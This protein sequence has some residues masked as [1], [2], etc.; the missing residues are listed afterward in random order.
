MTGGAIPEASWRPEREIEI[1]AGTP[2]GGGLDRSARALLKVIESNK[3]TDVPVKVINAGGDGGRKAWVHMERHT[4]D[5]HVI[6]IS[7]PNMAADYLTGVTKSDPDRFPPLAILYSEYIAFVVRADSDLRG[8]ADLIQRVARD[9]AS[10]RIALS[11]SLG[12][13]N[14]VAMAKVIRHAGGDTR[15]PD[16]RVFDTALDAVADVVAGHADVGAITAASAV[17]EL[18]AGRLRTIGISSPTRLSGPY[19]AAP[20]WSEQG[21]D[22]VI[23]SWRGA[24]GPPGLDGAQIAFWQATLAAA[25]RTVEWRAELDRH[26]WTD[27]Y[28]DG[29]ALRDYLARERTEMKAMLGE[30]GLL[31]E[32][33]T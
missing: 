20:T 22:C 23:G 16:I 21:V 11:T 24:S 2:P 32:G 27:M 19:A 15:A 9:A 33:G 1:V 3:L 12:N 13:S 28:L 4:G 25:A 29:A 17:P 14:H 31:T 18:E 5:G 7:S 30:L 8:G 6:G 10:V 26:F